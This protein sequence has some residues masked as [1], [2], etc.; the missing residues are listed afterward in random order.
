VRQRFVQAHLP[1]GDFENLC[2]AVSPKKLP[3]RAKRRRG[4][5]ARRSHG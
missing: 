1:E 4:Q 2:D 5:G 3:A